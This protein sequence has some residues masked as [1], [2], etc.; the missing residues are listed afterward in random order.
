MVPRGRERLAVSSTPVVLVSVPS[1]QP[2]L[3]LVTVNGAGILVTVEG[4]T[5]S[6]TG[7]SE[8]GVAYAE[9]S[10]FWLEGEEIGKAKFLRGAS[11]DAYL[12]VLYSDLD[13]KVRP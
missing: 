5:P 10:K 1:P 13:R 8:V 7:G 12:E 11:T 4:S 9:D 2:D 6:S 3:A